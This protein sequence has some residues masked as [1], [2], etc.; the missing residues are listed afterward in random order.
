[1]IP[2]TEAKTWRDHLQALG[3]ALLIVLSTLLLL[4]ALLRLIDPWG[5]RYF[6]DLARMGNELFIY[7]EARG[8]LME[9][10]DHSFSHWRASIRQGVRVV[11][12]TNPEAACTLA[13]LGDSVAFGYGVDDEQA[14]ANL[15][16]A[17]FPQVRV[18]NAAIPRYNSTNVLLSARDLQARGGADAYFYLIIGNDIEAPM[19]IRNLRFNGDGAGLPQMVRYLNFAIFRG[20]GTDYSPAPEGDTTTLDDSPAMR[21]LLGEMAELSAIPN[22][23]L[24]AFQYEPLT[25][26]LLEAG[27]DLALLRY[28]DRRISL[29]DYHLNPQGNAELAEQI[30]PLWESILAQACPSEDG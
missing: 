20:G 28:P 11:P 3:G 27:F 24:A 4:E 9:D 29:A 25:N 23:H 5:L 8:Y 2:T 15:L 30:A 16:A 26:T 6:N 10:G 14:W 19:D 22:M 13:V 18:I 21:R 1:M 7:D 12:A 17:R